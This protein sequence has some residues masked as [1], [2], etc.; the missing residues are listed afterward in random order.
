MKIARR[1]ALAAALVASLV[2]LLPIAPDA[3]AQA[4]PNRPI[5]WVVGF[6]AGGGSDVIARAIAAAISPA[7]GQPVLVE[8]RPGAAGSIAAEAV[9]KA[10]ADGYT[11]FTGD[12]GIMVFNTMVYK[13]MPYDPVRDF[14]PVTLIANF[15][16]LLVVPPTS[17]IR[18]LAE[19]VEA[20]RKE[21]GKI[22]YGSPGAGSPHHLAMELF[23]DMAKIDIVHAPYRGGAPAMQDLMAGTVPSLFID[24]VS[25][26]GAIKGG[27]VRALAVSTPKRIAALPDIPTF[28]ESGFPQYT[29]SAFQGVVVPAAT[30]REIV[31][32]LNKELVTAINSPEM[33]K[34][35]SDLGVEPAAGTPEQFADMLKADR[36]KW[37]ALIKSRGIQLDL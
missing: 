27:K 19:Y 34:R 16:L 24:F 21:P 4:W 20:A 36:Q 15:P 23:R 6:P 32:R 31:A 28:I 13:Q 26:Q 12:N 2:T 7:L 33:T 14:A 9:A 37:P 29:S 10:P 30:P 22:A 18:S 1:T 35:L 17:N 25:A 3:A 8:N 11:I 5:R